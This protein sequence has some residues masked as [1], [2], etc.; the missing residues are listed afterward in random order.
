MS[1][2]RRKD[3]GLSSREYEE[4]VVLE[5]IFQLFKRN[6]CSTCLVR[7]CTHVDPDRYKLLCSSCASRCPFRIHIGTDHLSM[8]VLEKLESIYWQK[9]AHKLP[10]KSPVR[11]SSH[12]RSHHYRDSSLSSVSSVEISK[13]PHYRKAQQL[14]S[15]STD[16]S[17]RRHPA[18]RKKS[19][20]HRQ[21]IS[22]ASSFADTRSKRYDKYDPM[23]AIVR[24]YSRHRDFD[25]KHDYRPRMDNYEQMH[26]DYHVSSAVYGHPEPYYSDYPGNVDKSFQ[27]K[28]P[29]GYDLP[30]IDD[31]PGMGGIMA[32]DK[33][34][35]R[36]RHADSAW[37][38]VESSTNRAV[39]HILTRNGDYYPPVANA[40]SGLRPESKVGPRPMVKG[41]GS[42]NNRREGRSNP[43]AKDDIN[44]NKGGTNRNHP[45][46][47]DAGR[48][49][50]SSM[51][52]ALQ[53]N[54]GPQPCCIVDTYQ[55]FERPIGKG[56]R[57]VADYGGLYDHRGR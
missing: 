26:P 6:R 45:N 5:R 56:G 34:G 41:F 47:Q 32:G 33:P 21:S 13:S 48:F 53:P 40:R 28:D 12:H 23:N 20:G 22:S 7:K 52:V 9:K 51:R 16:E 25:E 2:P 55:G 44:I 50:M 10:T 3:L 42:S 46:D 37:P 29:H 1:R 19:H 4:A 24:A 11:K 30:V 8:S 36:H 57:Y 31:M 15:A 14:R 18:T 27:R 35:R 38:V 43:F 39:D 49:N 17:S 54:D